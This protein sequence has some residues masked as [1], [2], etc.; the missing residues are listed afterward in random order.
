M[1]TLLGTKTVGPYLLTDVVINPNGYVIS[2]DKG[3]SVI[4]CVV[5]VSLWYPGGGWLAVPLTQRLYD[6]PAAVR[7][8]G[9]WLSPPL[10]RCRPLRRY[11]LW[12]LRQLVS[13]PLSSCHGNNNIYLLTLLACN[14]HYNI[15]Y[16]GINETL[17]LF[18]AQKNIVPYSSSIH[19]T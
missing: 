19:K 11:L 3:Y 16:C 15:S 6:A 4:Y 18:N 1:S 7:F 10:H 17:S 2:H 12:L 9:G 5:V 14:T 13:E 8:S